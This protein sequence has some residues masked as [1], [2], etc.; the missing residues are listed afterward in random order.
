MPFKCPTCGLDRWGANLRLT[1]YRDGYERLLCRACDRRR[2]TARRR[3]KGQ[4]A[5]LPIDP[6]RVRE[7]RKRLGM[8][9]AEFAEK[10]G[11]C[12]MTISHF[13]RGKWKFAR[14]A[15]QQAIAEIERRAELQEAF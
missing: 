9:Q 13:E 8:T 5:M 14:S 4:A 11:F 1:T 12:T 3:A 15:F 6:Q 10:L 2:S 7:L